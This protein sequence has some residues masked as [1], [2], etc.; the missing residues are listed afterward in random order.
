MEIRYLPMFSYDLLSTVAYI[1]EVL[2][3]PVAAEKFIN[4]VELGI[5]KES[6]NPGISE[7]YK[8]KRNLEKTYYKIRVGNYF[9]FYTLENDVMI[10]CRLIYA[11]RN[12]SIL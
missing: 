11:R 4:D 7:P 1:S 8:A 2:M 5:L 12:M 3:N 6:L 10:V 9:V